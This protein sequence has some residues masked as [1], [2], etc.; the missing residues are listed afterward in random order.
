MLI[1]ENIG[2]VISIMA[3]ALCMV[4]KQVYKIALEWDVLIKL[5]WQF[6]ISLLKGLRVSKLVKIWSYSL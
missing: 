4:V 3:P 1:S 2:N 6:E 5:Y